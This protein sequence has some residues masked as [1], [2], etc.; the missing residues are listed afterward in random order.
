MDRL[1]T[2]SPFLLVDDPITREIVESSRLWHLARRGLRPAGRPGSR[3]ER[4]AKTAG[5][6][7]GGGV[8]NH[9]HFHFEGP[10][11]AGFDPSRWAAESG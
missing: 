7:A 9:Y 5:R 8:H 3:Q 10:P 11:S 6:D 2:F 4:I 1:R